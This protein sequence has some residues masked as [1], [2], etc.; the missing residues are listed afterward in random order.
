M[1][2]SMNCVENVIYWPEITKYFDGVKTGGYST[3]SGRY[4]TVWSYI[5]KDQNIISLKSVSNSM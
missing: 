4:Q 3:S 2:V 1:D 5:P